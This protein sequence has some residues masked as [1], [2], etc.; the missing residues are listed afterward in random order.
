LKPGAPLT[1]PT[2]EEP[3][4]ARDDPEDRAGHEM[5]RAAKVE[6]AGGLAA[7]LAAELRKDMEALW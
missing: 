6:K 4:P 2:P 5:Q 3:D 7:I 1:F